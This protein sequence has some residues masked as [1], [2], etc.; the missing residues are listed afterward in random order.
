MWVIFGLFYSSCLPHMMPL[1][2]SQEKIVLILFI[3]ML[4]KTFVST[5]QSFRSTQT[6][7]RAA[8][9]VCAC[10]SHSVKTESGG[11]YPAVLC[12]IHSAAGTT[13]YGNCFILTSPTSVYPAW[14]CLKLLLHQA[15]RASWH[16]TYT[17]SHTENKL[18]C[19]K[20]L[21]LLS[22][23]FEWSPPCWPDPVPC[24]IFP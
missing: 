5:N 8:V 10:M 9:H 13:S 19:K 17:H 20:Y 7:S 15:G 4:M 18:G 3:M 2:A 21:R 11:N 16:I 24:P 12:H 1:S 22:P 14:G 6:Q 23:T